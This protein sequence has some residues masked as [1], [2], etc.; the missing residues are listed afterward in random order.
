MLVWTLPGLDG[1]DRPRS[2]VQFGVQLLQRIHHQIVLVL[3]GLHRG[4]AAGHGG[5]VG[6]PVGQRGLTDAA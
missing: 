1:P 2:L 4:L 5:V 6:D 3:H